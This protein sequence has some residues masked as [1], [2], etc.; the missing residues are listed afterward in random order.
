MLLWGSCALS[1][2]YILGLV[3]PPIGS[4]RSTTGSARR[5]VQ[6]VFPCTLPHL[7]CT[8]F[9][10]AMVECLAALPERFPVATAI[11]RLCLLSRLG[12]L[13]LD[14]ASIAEDYLG[15]TPLGTR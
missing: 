10:S 11:P 7:A 9:T 5:A 8:C 15:A 12:A 13:T 6:A 14:Q 3:D 4:C 1:F 2:S